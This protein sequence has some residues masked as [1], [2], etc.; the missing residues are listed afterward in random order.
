MESEIPVDI[1]YEIY[2]LKQ[3]KDIKIEPLKGDVKGDSK[4]EVTITF[5]PE[6]SSTAVCE[7][8]IHLSQFDFQPQICRVSGSGVPRYTEPKTGKIESPKTVVSKPNEMSE[9]KTKQ[10]KTLL[11]LKGSSSIKSTQV[12]LRYYK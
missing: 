6:A 3:H 10:A 12:F 4:T 9:S 8:E 1:E 5:R 2:I 11:S 7:F